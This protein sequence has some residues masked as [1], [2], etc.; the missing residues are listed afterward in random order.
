MDWPFA[1]RRGDERYILV[2]YAHEE[3]GVV[4]CEVQWLKDQGSN[5]WNDEGIS[6]GSEWR[7]EFA[8]SWPDCSIPPTIR[9]SM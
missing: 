5:I 1:A 2:S 8:D 9:W 3:S 6:P 7:T 4:F